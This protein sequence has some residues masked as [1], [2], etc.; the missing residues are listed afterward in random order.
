MLVPRRV[1]GFFHSLKVTANAPENSAKTPQKVKLIFQTIDFQVRA[2][3]FREGISPLEKPRFLFS[4]VHY[5]PAIRAKTRPYFLGK[6]EKEGTQRFLHKKGKIPTVVFG[7]SFE[8]RASVRLNACHNSCAVSSKRNA[9]VSVSHVIFFAHECEATLH[10]GAAGGDNI[11]VS[12]GRPI[13]DIHTR[14]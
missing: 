11:Q 9:H 3:S 1:R 7:S 10:E 2:V 8:A 14:T 5:D 12:A 13:L 6:W 4:Y